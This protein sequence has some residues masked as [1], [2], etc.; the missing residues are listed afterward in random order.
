M[1]LGHISEPHI[2]SVAV[3]RLNRTTFNLYVSLAYTGGGVITHFNVSFRNT[4][5]TSW[6][7][8]GEIPA[9]P[10]PNSSLVWNGVISRDDFDTSIPLTFN[11][12]AVNTHGLKSAR[13]QV[14]SL[15]GMLWSTKTWL[16]VFIVINQP[17]SCSS[18]PPSFPAPQYWFYY[19]SSYVIPTPTS[20]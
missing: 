10:S 20:Y 8:L 13:A 7:P 2:S 14:N 19:S 6:H 9:I 15:S 16:C 3:T 11:V 4:G 5:A 18:S 17:L 12:L 1:P